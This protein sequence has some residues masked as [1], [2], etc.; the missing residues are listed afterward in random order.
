MTASVVFVSSQP[1]VN[2]SALS[3]ILQKGDVNLQAIAFVTN[4][5]ALPEGALPSGQFSV[6][7]SL[8]EENGAHQ[9][10]LL[11]ELYRSLKHGGTLTIIEKDHKA[12]SS[13]PGQEH[14][15]FECDILN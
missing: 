1:C 13:G 6:A 12:S 9:G 5:S 8:A 15:N 14:H 3:A 11:K 10:Q 4:S 7:F 2:G